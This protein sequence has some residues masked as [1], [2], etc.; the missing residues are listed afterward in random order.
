[1]TKTRTGI[2][3]MCSQSNIARLAVRRHRRVVQGADTGDGELEIV[4]EGR[5]L[6]VEGQGH[7]PDQLEAQREHGIVIVV[8]ALSPPRRLGWP[9]VLGSVDVGWRRVARLA[10]IVLLG[11]EGV[12]THGES[13]FDVCLRATKTDQH[14]ATART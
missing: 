5:L 2:V 6:Q 4:V 14:E 7:D 9:Y 13:L 1:M 8:Q 10:H 12:I 3:A 11:L